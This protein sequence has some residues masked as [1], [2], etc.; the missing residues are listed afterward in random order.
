MN[1]ICKMTCLRTIVLHN[2]PSREVWRFSMT[3]DKVVWGNTPFLSNHPTHEVKRSGNCSVRAGDVIIWLFKWWIWK[4][5][6]SSEEIVRMS[7]L[8]IFIVL[9]QLQQITG[10]ARLVDPPQRSSLWRYGYKGAPVNERD[11]ELNCGGFDVSWN[12]F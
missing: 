1:K 6:I 11:G 2:P 9:C 7:L 5:T 3:A 10:F 12:H 4:Q 8:K